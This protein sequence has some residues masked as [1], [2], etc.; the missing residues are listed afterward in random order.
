M[1]L[2]RLIAIVRR[3]W[4]LVLLPPLL[5]LAGGLLLAGRAPYV[6]TARATVLLPGDIDNPG[7]ASQP[8]PLAMDDVTGLVR[9]QAFAA[10]VAGRLAAA[11]RGKIGAAVHACLDASYFSRTVIVTCSSRDRARAIVIGQAAADALPA[12]INQYLIPAG[13]QPATV[14]VID[15]PTDAGRDLGR[16]LLVLAVQV[17]AALAAGIGLAALAAALDRRLYSAEEV[18]QALGLPVLAD[19]RGRGAGRGRA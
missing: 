19:R 18:G 4:W 1:D 11:G 16:R 13:G 12:A 7:N 10:L 15:R 9:S 14:R 6:A 5:V 8:L 17:L 2:P 3:R